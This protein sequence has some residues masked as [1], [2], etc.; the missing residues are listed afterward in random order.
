MEFIHLNNVGATL[1]SPV[2]DFSSASTMV[3]NDDGDL[4]LSICLFG[5]CLSS[6]E[7]RLKTF[8][9][10]T[11]IQYVCPEGQLSDLN[12]VLAP[13]SEETTEDDVIQQRQP[14]PRP[15]YR[16]TS[17]AING[18][19]WIVGGRDA[20]NNIIN[21]IDV[22]DEVH[23]EWTTFDDAEGL[24]SYGVSDHCAFSYGPYLFIVGGYD[25]EYKAVKNTIMIRTIESLEEE[26][27]NFQLRAPM[28]RARGG[29]SATT[30]TGDNAIVAGGF[31]HEDGYCE[32]TRSV[33]MYNPHHDKWKVF[34]HPMAYGRAKPSLLR[35][36]DNKI[37]AFGGETRG[38]HDLMYGKCHGDPYSLGLDADI[39]LPNRLTYPVDHVEIFDFGAY[40][41]DEEWYIQNSKWVVFQVRKRVAST[42]L[43]IAHF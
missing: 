3:A 37:F 30:T 10:R 24:G 41:Y 28:N 4:V 20:N 25:Q 31:T 8:D 21:E 12:L 15:R 26:K 34:A 38:M 7:S 42:F 2:T 23:D 13:G 36:D 18:K 39:Y 9:V 11:G 32:A 27:L 5:G 1:P 35:L 43:I 33:E 17:V 40:D 22:Y 19:I 6:Y 14:M 29:C 16:H